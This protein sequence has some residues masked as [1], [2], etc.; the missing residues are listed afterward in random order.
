M[1][2][3]F[4]AF[5]VLVA[6]GG[7]WLSVLGQ[8]PYTGP[9]PWAIGVTYGLVAIGSPGAPGHCGARAPGLAGPAGEDIGM[10]VLLASWVLVYIW[11]AAFYK[12]GHPS[13]TGS[14]R[15]PHRS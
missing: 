7:L 11:A 5:V 9:K 15:P 14:T 3:V 13:S 10:G 12:T 8:H 4:R 6:F 1:L 2:N